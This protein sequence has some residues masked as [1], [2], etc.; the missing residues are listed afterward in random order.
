VERAVRREPRVVDEDLDVESEL[1]DPV[2][3]AA[4]RRGLAEVARD[5]FDAD[6]VLAGELFGELGEPGLASRHEDEPV[7]ACGELS[8]DVGPDPGRG[9]GDERG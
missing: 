9:A 5:R 1:L 4:T 7:A 2:G 6:S 3:E 8:S